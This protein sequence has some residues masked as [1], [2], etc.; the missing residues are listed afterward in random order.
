[1]STDGCYY[2]IEIDYNSH[3]SHSANDAVF[4]KDVEINCD[5]CSL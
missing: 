2:E 5:L 3:H 1:M 4:V